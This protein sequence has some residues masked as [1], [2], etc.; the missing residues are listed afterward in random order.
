[1]AG[2]YTRW[3]REGT[4]KVVTGSTALL[5]T[6]TYWLTAGLNPGDIFSVDGVH[7]YEI[8]S[9][10]DNTHITLKT[11]YTGANDDASQYHII[12]NF[13]AQVPSQLA[14]QLADLYSD[15]SRYWDQDTQTVHGKSAYEI[16]V[17]NGY[18][19]TEAEWLDFLRNGGGFTD[20][21]SKIEPITYHNASAHNSIYRGKYLGTEITDAMHSAIWNSN[22]KDLYPGDY[23]R[24]SVNG[25]TVT[26]YI[27]RFGYVTANGTWGTSMTLWLYNKIWNAPINDTNTC[28]GHLLNSKLYTETFP[29]IL[30]AMQ[31]VI[32]PDWIL[33]SY[34]PI[35]D[36]I[37]AE[38]IVNHSS[39]YS[40]IGADLCSIFL[41]SIFNLGFPTEV[42]LDTLA[43]NEAYTGL[44]FNYWPFARHFQWYN[45]GSFWLSANS[46]ATHWMAFESSLSR[47]AVPTDPSSSRYVMPYIII[48]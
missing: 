37:N 32:N 10:T 13:T 46:D 23:F 29:E 15:L 12:R 7:D 36:S 34:M 2:T 44:G 17:L 27:A 48:I 47:K 39:W 26:A 1:M 18:V 28:E 4:V 41:P 45:F 6:N 11:A 43:K 20:L 33:K 5:G 38:G 16:A 40:Y 24:F 21:V 9:I 30:E 19:G 3:Y 35:A 22:Y 25:S 31:S 14:S 8:F 42:P